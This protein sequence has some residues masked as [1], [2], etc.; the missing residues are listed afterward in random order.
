MFS[1]RLPKQFHFIFIGCFNILG[2]GRVVNPLQ[3]LNEFL[4]CWKKWDMFIRDTVVLPFKAMS[5]I[6]DP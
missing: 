1:L 3:P 4:E 2:I 5:F 6:T